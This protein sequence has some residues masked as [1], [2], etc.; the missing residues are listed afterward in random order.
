MF[1]VAWSGCARS[2]QTDLCANGLPGDWDHLNV[3]SNALERH[4]FFAEE[5]HFKV[6]RNLLALTKNKSDKQ[7]EREKKK[8]RK[9]MKEALPVS[10]YKL[11]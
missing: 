5:K 9:E 6:M 7:R 2:H 10:C 11:M 1:S 3:K 8:T 4:V